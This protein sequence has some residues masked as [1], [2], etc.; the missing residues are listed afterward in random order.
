MCVHYIQI[1]I[2]PSAVLHAVREHHVLRAEA[3][4]ERCGGVAR[5]DPLQACG[6]IDEASAGGHEEDLF[7]A[8]R[9]GG[10]RAAPEQRRW[11]LPCRL[12]V[13]AEVSEALHRIL[14]I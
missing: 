7:G 5:G 3:A 1:Y 6:E 11:T 2:T 8:L 12:I 14:D 4:R 9:C 13:V 10:R